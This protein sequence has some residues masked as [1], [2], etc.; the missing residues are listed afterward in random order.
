MMNTRWLKPWSVVAFILVVTAV[1]YARLLAAPGL[2]WD[3][4]SNIFN[5]PYYQAGWWGQFWIGPY[6]GLYVPITSFV[7]QVLF[8]IGG[9]AAWPYRVLNLLLHLGNTALVY[10]VL[11]GLARRWNL[12]GAWIAVIGTAVF[13]LHPLQV[14]TVA[15]LSGG[16]DLLATC[17]A[18]LATLLY[19][20]DSQPRTLALATLCFMLSL[21][22]KPSG[23]MLPFVLVLFDLLIEPKRVR[24]AAPWL[25][26]WL[27]LCFWPIVLTQAG[28]ADVNV[29]T[30]WWA[31]PWLML[32]AYAFYIRGLVLPWP[33]SGN[34]ART[35]D[36]VLANS[37]TLIPAVAVLVAT[38]GLAAYAWLK[39][40][41]LFSGLGWMLLLL[42]VSG[43]VPFAYQ[44][45]S[46]TADHYMYL[47]M[48]ALAAFLMLALHTLAR[49]HRPVFILC[50]IFLVG[51]AGVSFARVNVWQSDEAFFT[52]MANYAPKAYST[53]IGMSIVMCQGRKDYD[54]GVR[55]TEVALAERPRD[56]MALANQAYCFLHAG[57]HFRVTELE[58]YLDQM[59]LRDLEEKQ[60]T[61]Y[62][63]L[64]ASI[65]T[66]KIELKDYEDGYQYLCEAYRIKPSEPNHAR[67]LEIAGEI[68][69]NQNI[70]P[71]CE[72]E[73]DGEV[74]GEGVDDLLQ[75]Q[76]FHP[77]GP[78]NEDPIEDE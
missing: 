43:L 73:V 67:N 28:Q 62:S 68:L 69:K 41:R 29:V 34:Y 50:V 57:N 4:D 39:D 55:W 6:F 52:D 51:C 11:R 1:I 65:G 59:N 12:N 44:K 2:T 8:A 21:L 31:R 27:L 74:D 33:L 61:A 13:A 42:P 37:R 72:N 75:P 3:D 30:E 70:E 32:D 58:F 38:C 71:F 48:V 77:G 45:I 5:N 49:W 23:V 24:Q 36:T 35:P 56:I 18:L 60:P 7:W 25:A 64:L 10:L 46:T 47:P 76:D 40:K 26:V 15:W 78:I 20:R 53:G 19:F 9:G 16:R 22:S 66:A 17:F 54:E 63:S 14:E